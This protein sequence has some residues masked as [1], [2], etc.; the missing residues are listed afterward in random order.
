MHAH[1]CVHVCA[2]VCVCAH[3]CVCARMSVLLPQAP[4]TPYHLFCLGLPLPSFTSSVFTPLYCTLHYNNPTPSSY[5]FHSPSFHFFPLKAVF[6]YAL[7][8]CKESSAAGCICL[9]CSSWNPLSAGASLGAGGC[10]QSYYSSV[11]KGPPR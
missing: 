11:S 5:P 8:L 2:C 7:I 6:T 9:P 10:R 1:V 4:L 3:M